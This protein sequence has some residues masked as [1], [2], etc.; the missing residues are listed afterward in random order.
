MKLEGHAHTWRFP[1]QAAQG[2][3]TAVNLRAFHSL[4][5]LGPEGADSVHL[6]RRGAGWGGGGVV[7]V[8]STC[9]LV[10]ERRTTCWVTMRV[11]DP[12][13]PI[14]RRPLP[15]REGR[16]LDHHVTAC[17]EG[18]GVRGHAGGGGAVLGLLSA[19]FLLRGGGGGSKRPAPLFPG[20]Q[21][22]PAHGLHPRFVVAEIWADKGAGGGGGCRAAASLLSLRAAACGTPG[23]LR[24]AGALPS[25]ARVRSGLKC[26]PGMGGGE[27]R[28]V[29]R[30]PGG[31]S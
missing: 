5:F 8:G 9:S 4:H 10:W 24:V 16:D 1:R 15:V 27:G 25:G 22:G 14:V 6:S 3:P 11:P 19:P 7:V 26:R 13:I 12:N 21:G 28:P 18:A 30:S 20:P 17:S 2:I 31:P 23:P 29:D